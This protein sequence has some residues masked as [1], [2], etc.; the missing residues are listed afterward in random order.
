[1]VIDVDHAGD[2]TASAQ[3]S[4]PFGH[5]I[6]EDDCMNDVITRRGIMMRMVMLIVM[7]MVVLSMIMLGPTGLGNIPKIVFLLLLPL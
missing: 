3:L 5:N 7:R 1:M 4:F 2:N 6:D